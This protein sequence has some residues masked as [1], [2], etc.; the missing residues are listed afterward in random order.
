M[1]I[2]LWILALFLLAGPAL[3]LGDAD[4]DPYLW[5]EDILG[6]KS[7][8]WVRERNSQCTAELTQ[9]AQFAPMR[10]RFLSILDS[11]ER[12]PFVGKRGSLY[13]NFWRDEKNRRGLWRRTTLEEFR[14]PSP[15][16]ETVLDLDALSTAEGENWVFH[17]ANWLD[18]E[19]DRCLFSL[20]RGGADAAVVREFDPVAKAFVKDGFSLPEAK[21]HVAWSDRDHLLVGTNFGAGSMTDSGYPRVVKEW[22]RGTP[23][24]EAQTVFEGQSSDV[25]VSGWADRTPG[26]ERVFVERSINFYENELYFRSGGKL[27]KL[28]KPNDTSA[29]VHREW[30]LFQPRTAWT[31]NGRTYPAG[32]LLAARFDVFLSGKGHLD[33]LFTP[34]ERRSLESFAPTRNHIL[35]NELDNVKSR[36]YVLTAKDGTWTREAVPGMPACGHA[37]VGAVDSSTSDDYFLTVEDFL[38]PVTLAMGHA[39]GGAAETLKAAPSFFQSAG[40]TVSQHEATSKDGTRVPYFQI[41]RTDLKLDGKTPALLYGYGGFEVSLVPRYS[42]IVGAG[43]CER[44]STYIVANIRGGGEFGPQWHQAALKEKRLRAYEDF[45]AVAGD[46]VQR[47]VTSVPH[48]GIQG[49]SNGGLLMGNMLTLYPQLFGAVVCQVPLL[50]MRRYHKLLAGASWMAEYG[51]PDNPNEWSFIRSFSPYHNLKEEATYPRTLFTTSTRDDRVHP[52]HAR[53]M[54][55]RMLEMKH[56]VLYY[57]NV[58][59]GHG[60]AADNTQ[61]AFMSA[62]AFTFLARQLR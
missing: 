40:L 31:F 12:I 55:A 62:L 42:G 10:D 2:D 41:A 29:S 49:G 57:E 39:G 1:R 7:L 48:L 20:S 35:V 54:M 51:D 21:S 15:Q 32:S 25:S 17:G 45:A 28:A 52:G 19:Y 61:T 9:D 11:K 5:L 26:F 59:G 3:A 38:T 22:K 36:L 56:N 27:I 46:L 24:A 58:E 44:G 4:A 50:D 18:P 8:A 30:I 16:W 23:L 37:S 43:W 60:G 53:K 6:E 34:A 33:I 13:Y 47:G 14:K